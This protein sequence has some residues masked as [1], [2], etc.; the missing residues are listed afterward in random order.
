ME[1]LRIPYYKKYKHAH[2]NKSAQEDMYLHTDTLSWFRANQSLLLLISAVC[3]A[4]K[5]QT[6]IL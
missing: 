5:Q 1:T 6:L 4:K 3:L 2:W